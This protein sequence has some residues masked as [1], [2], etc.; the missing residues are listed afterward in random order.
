MWQMHKRALVV[1][2]RMSVQSGHTFTKLD[3]LY[4]ALGWGYGHAAVHVLFLFGSLLPLTTG[5]GTVYSTSCPDMSIF[6]VGALNS[7]GLG[8]TLVAL[9]VIA[10]DG[11]SRGSLVGKS[12]A[13]VMHAGAALVTLGS[14][15]RGGCITSVAAQLALGLVNTWYAASIAWKQGGAAASSTGSGVVSSRPLGTAGAAAR[16]EG[17]S[18]GMLDVPPE[19]IGESTAIVSPTGTP[20]SARTRRS[21]PG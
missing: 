17:S 11:W 3:E 15:R 4:L 18:R 9:S 19:P 10:L 14:F 16:D 21:R 12:Y 13:P 1:L 2:H 7:L 6:L 5:H 8:A 20:G